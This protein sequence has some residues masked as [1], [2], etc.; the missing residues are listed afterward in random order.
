MLGISAFGRRSAA[1]VVVD[2]E[3]VAAAHEERFSRARG[4]GAFP[5]RAVRACLLQAG[6]EASKL[7][8]VAFHEKPLRAFERVLASQLRAF[9]HSSGPFARTMFLWLGDRLWTRGRIAEELAVPP[10]RV[11]FVAHHRAQAAHAFAAAPCDAAGVLIVDEGVE[12]P[13]TTLAR[14]HERGLDVLG[15]IHF[16]HSLGLLAAALTQFLGFEPGIEGDLVEALS[17]FGSARF[18][19]QLDA[20]VPAGEAGAFRVDPRP[21]RFPFDGEPLFGP[22]LEERLG[23]R[24]H[25][26][27]PV[28]Y[29]GADTRDA[30]VARALQ[31]VLEERVLALAHELH[32]RVPEPA[33]CL[34]GTL[35]HNRHL[36]ARLAVDG[37]F[38]ELHV[39]PDGGAGGAAVG[40]ALEV[41]RSLGT[42]LRRGWRPDLGEALHE[43]GEDGA[44]TLERDPADELAERLARGERVAWVRG[45]MDFAPESLGHRS[46]FADPRGAD[47]RGRLLGSLRQTE[48]FR[49]C[50]V[51][52]RED[53]A[54]RF[55]DLAPGALAAAR[56]AQLVAPAR[57][58]LRAL[59]PS[60]VAPDGVAWPHVVARE[61]DPELWT[62]LARFEE[63][64]DCPLLLHA[65]LAPRGAP[66]VRTEG[67]AVDAFRRS[68]LDALVVE[69]RLYERA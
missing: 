60:A 4:D 18:E 35:A 37:P 16:P 51:A 14:A 41:A 28:R 3:P 65:T 32:R 48:S 45:R 27:S 29:E 20:L 33:L 11:A 2:G 68:E 55:V 7:D 47:A 25:P 53:A 61:D 43:L 19:P 26:G 24:R 38:A 10:K 30:D 9:P 22:G 23:P 44:R 13:T 52:L 66:M 31:H 42:T 67:D 1:A 63:R 39:A 57:E 8:A 59:A 15:E 36:C 5:G 54:A 56:R 12:W 49:P 62:L 58:A 64:S 21:F 6:I 46:L 50:R 40:A 17:A 69:G 34:G